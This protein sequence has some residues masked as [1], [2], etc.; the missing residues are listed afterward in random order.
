MRREWGMRILRVLCSLLEEVLD[1]FIT[2]A[3]MVFPSKYFAA[4]L[5]Y[6]V[7]PID[8]SIKVQPEWDFADCQLLQVKHSTKTA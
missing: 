8:T 1:R 4:R 3:D 6:S 2:Q 5:I 7:P